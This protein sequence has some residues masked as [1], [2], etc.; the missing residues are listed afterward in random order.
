M[1]VDSVPDRVADSVPGR[2]NAGWSSTRSQEPSACL[3]AGVGV[4]VVPGRG[5]PEGRSGRRR[6]FSSGTGGITARTGE[7]PRAGRSGAVSSADHL[8]LYYLIR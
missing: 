4:G 6:E 2:V 3:R 1:H 5:G 8:Q 7:I